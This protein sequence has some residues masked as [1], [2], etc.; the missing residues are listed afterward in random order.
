M[1]T[2]KFI[3]NSIDTN[4]INDNTNTD[5][6]IANSVLII[7]TILS[8]MTIIRILFMVIFITV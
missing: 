2:S 8:M 5:S 6:I 7:T 1:C 4:S 3:I